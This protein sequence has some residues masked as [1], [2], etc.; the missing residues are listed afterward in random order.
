[1][2]NVEFIE[3]SHRYLYDG[4]IVPVSVTQLISWKLGT[5]YEDVPEMVLKRKA[6][7][8]TRIHALIEDYLTKGEY[9]ANGS[10]E[11][12][13]MEAFKDLQRKLP[14]IKAVE[15]IVCFEGR[16][17]GKID[18]IFQDG[19]IGDIKT[20][21]SV[22]D[23]ALEK[24]KWQISLYLFCKYGKQM[25]K[26]KKNFLVHL[27]KSMKY[28]VKQIDGIYTYSKCLKLLEEYEEAHK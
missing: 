5:G 9:N 19:S 25:N 2:M 11:I 1:M 7:Y 22:D 26:R 28:S 15:E 12:A 6:E 27:P 4:I 20:Y 24:L 16:L 10:Y 21:A 14:K 3:S 13:T 23:L 8:G 17:A 18:L